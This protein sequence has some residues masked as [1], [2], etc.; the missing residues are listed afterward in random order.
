M[1]KQQQGISQV[2]VRGREGRESVRSGESQTGI[3]GDHIGK[4]KE[5]L[6]SGGASAPLP[7]NGSPDDE[8]EMIG[9]TRCHN[10]RA[11]TVASSSL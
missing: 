10:N 4:V 9:G 6:V 1:H 7:L 11:I 3:N 5:F 8:S 2:K